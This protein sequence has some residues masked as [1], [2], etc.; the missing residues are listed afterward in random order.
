M[1]I[2]E[3]A[4]SDLGSCGKPL[5]I[6]AF[7]SK[8]YGTATVNSDTDYKIIY[9][10]SKEDMLIGYHPKTFT[11]NSSDDHTK[12]TKD[13]IDI[14]YKPLQ[15]FLSELARGDTGAVDIAFSYTNP[16]VTKICDDRMNFF[17]QNVDKFFTV[18]NVK[19]FV[20]F[21]QSQAIKYSVKGERLSVLS[22]IVEYLE[23][24]REAYSDLCLKHFYA[25]LIEQCGHESYCF[26]KKD[27]PYV[28]VLDKMYGFGITFTYFA[29]Q[30]NNVYLKYGERAKKVM[31]EYQSKEISADWKSLSHAYRC[32]YELNCL[33]DVKNIR[34]PLNCADI[35]RDIKLG[36]Y[37]LDKVSDMIYHMLDSANKKLLC[38]SHDESKYDRNTV[39]KFILEFY[40]I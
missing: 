30:I 34:F 17:F 22:D 35:I 37:T 25:D 38:I 29:N 21:A 23:K 16:H 15:N 14:E 7:G 2:Y 19:S 18:S 13:D 27:S 40:D 1:D 33:L 26:L 20:G 6:T 36:N 39:R 10:P 32:A 28:V 11:R 4:C 9:L 8:L 3:R 5:Y 31:Q 24:N 12:N